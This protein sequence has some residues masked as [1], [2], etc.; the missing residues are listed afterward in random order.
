MSRPEIA[1]MGSS[2]ELDA[3]G[4][5]LQNSCSH[6]HD[7]FIRLCAGWLAYELF[8]S[9]N[10]MLTYKSRHAQLRC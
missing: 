1:A 7:M 6:L 9:L 4:S 2:I 5:V 8:A 10:A 3:C